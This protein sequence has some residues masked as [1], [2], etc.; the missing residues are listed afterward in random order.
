MS[1][2][3]GGSSRSIRAV[4][5]CVS[6]SEPACA[7]GRRAVRPVHEDADLGIDPRRVGEGL[8]RLPGRCREVAVEVDAGRVLPRSGEQAVRVED[9]D[10][11]PARLGAGDPLQQP[12]HEQGRVRL[13]AVLGRR[14]EAGDRPVALRPEDPQRHAVARAA[15]LLDAPAVELAAQPR[16]HRTAIRTATSSVSS[17]RSL[18]HAA[19]RRH[20]GVVATDGDADVRLGLL[21]VVRRVER[22]PA[23]LARRGRPPTRARPTSLAPSG[24]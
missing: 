10:H 8:A 11:R 19:R 4:S 5:A 12:A 20:V 21:A 13:L 7:P 17:G 23:A 24:S 2:T 22:D 16:A 3:S 14:Q 18:E 15:V 1:T 9:G 6:G